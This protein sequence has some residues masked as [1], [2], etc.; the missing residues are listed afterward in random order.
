MCYEQSQSFGVS[1]TAKTFDPNQYLY[2]RK[3]EECELMSFCVAV[4]TDSYIVLASDSRSCVMSNT[5]PNGILHFSD[6]FEK[7]VHLPTADIS[8]IAAGQNRFNKLPICDYLRSVESKLIGLS[9]DKALVYVAE[10]LKEMMPEAG[11]THLL[12]AKR[13]E[14]FYCDL[15]QAGDIE[16]KP[17]NALWRAGQ[18]TDI[19]ERLYLASEGEKTLNIDISA[20]SLEDTI[21]FAKH[22]INTQIEYNYFAGRVPTIGGPIQ[23][24]ALSK[25]GQV[26]I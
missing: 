10:H 25:D 22:I 26:S 7:I 13:Q 15:A 6:N 23:V 9:I 20:M 14:A 1:S 17:L 5:S 16:L 19:V 2:D 24:C 12:A 3:R 8:F 21:A 4:K 18:Q 11:I